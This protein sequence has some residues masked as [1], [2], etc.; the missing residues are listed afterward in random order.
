MYY[1]FIVFA[2]P[3]VWPWV[4]SPQRSPSVPAAVNTSWTSSSWRFW[5][6]I[7]TPSA[8]SAPTVRHRWRTNVS[9]GQEASTA[10]RT[11]SSQSHFYYAS[12]FID[13]H[14]FNYVITEQF[15]SLNQWILIFTLLITSANAPA[16]LNRSVVPVWNVSLSGLAEVH[17]HEWIIV[18]SS[19]L[20]LF[21]TTDI[22]YGLN[23]CIQSHLSTRWANISTYKSITFFIFG[24]W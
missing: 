13:S 3:G 6:D 21:S 23:I 5:T 18:Y 15:T 19:F 2:L 12:I 8:S 4:V 14:P 1:V 17:M 20:N 10:K 9:P 11:S 22:K 24:K 7:G 16:A